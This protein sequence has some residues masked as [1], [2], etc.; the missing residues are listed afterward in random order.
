MDN[1]AYCLKCKCKKE[2]KGGVLLKNKKNNKYIQGKCDTCGT[3]I[4]RILKKESKLEPMVIE[5][6]N[7]T[8]NNNINNN[9]DNN[10]NLNEDIIINKK[11]KR[12]QI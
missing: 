9:N 2:I 10:N 4:N 7:T 8:E 5:P 11:I 3:K 6:I 12:P 1:L